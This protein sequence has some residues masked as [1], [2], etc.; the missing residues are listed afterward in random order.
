MVRPRSSLPGSKTLAGVGFDVGVSVVAG[1]G[2]GVVVLGSRRNSPNRSFHPKSSI[3]PPIY[4]TAHPTHSPTPPCLCRAHHPHH[5]PTHPPTHLPSPC[6]PPSVKMRWLRFVQALGIGEDDPPPWLINMQR[7][8][9][10]ISYPHLRIPGLNAPI[11]SGAR[12][13]FGPSEWG[14]PPVDSK[15]N[16]LYGGELSDWSC[17]L[18]L[19]FRLVLLAVFEGEGCTHIMRTRNRMSAGPCILQCRDGARR[20]FAD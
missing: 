8:G 9:P 17:W 16:P 2:V 3:H 13:G 18:F 10:P 20:V 6:I 4:A 11:P 7:Y 19:N 1:A 15:G 14:K 12:Y 5:P